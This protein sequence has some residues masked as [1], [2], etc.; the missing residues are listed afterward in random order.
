MR[1][2]LSI[3][4]S[5]A[6]ILCLSLFISY[7]NIINNNSNNNSDTNLNNTYNSNKNI[8]MY[9]PNWGVYSES[10]NNLTVWDI[11]WDKITVINHAF[12]TV[13]K[14]FKLESTDK[15]ADFEKSFPNSEG[16]EQGQLR[17]HIGEYKYYKSKYPNV[18][19]LISLGGWTR[20]EN[21]HDMAKTKENRKIFIDSII[22]FLK[23]YPFIDGIDIDWEYPGENRTKV[24]NDVFDKG[25]HG[26]KYHGFK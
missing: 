4:T 5:I 19:V 6:L 20:G 9:F 15:D 8:I 16:W 10:H 26:G 17:G 7:R 2:K 24:P 14:D 22:D 11:P 25:C 18:K 23:K 1:K 3:S 12:F 21:F 13:S